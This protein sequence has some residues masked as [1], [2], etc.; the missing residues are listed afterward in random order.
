[1]CDKD[2]ASVRQ[3]PIAVEGRHSPYS[4]LEDRVHFRSMR[5]RLRKVLTG[6]L[7]LFLFPLA[8]HA[9]IY[10]ARDQR[11]SFRDANWSS[12]GM[13][14]AA[15][16]D[17]DARLLIFTGRTGRWKGAFSVHSWVVF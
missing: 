8:V 16:Q 13:L 7:A 3:R 5:S 17:R 1:M 6:L 15:S 12:T 4:S 11:G 2:A 14:P 9:A 10:T